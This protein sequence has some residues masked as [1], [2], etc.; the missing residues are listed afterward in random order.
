[1][2]LEISTINT[3]LGV[4]ILFQ[5]WIVREL[6]SLRTKLKVMMSHCPHCRAALT[7]VPDDL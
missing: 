6:F 4:V 2:N 3:L 5:A 1:V 7:P